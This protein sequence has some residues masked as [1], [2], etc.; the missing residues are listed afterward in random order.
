MLGGWLGMPLPGQWDLRGDAGS[1]FNAVLKCRGT[2]YPCSFTHLLLYF[3]GKGWTL[4]PLVIITSGIKVLREPVQPDTCNL[5]LSGTGVQ[6][7]CL[8][9]Q[10][11]HSSVDFLSKS[12]PCCQAALGFRTYNDRCQTSILLLSFAKLLDCPKPSVRE[13][14]LF[15]VC[16]FFFNSVIN[17]LCLA[18]EQAPGCAAGHSCDEKLFCCQ[19]FHV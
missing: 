16:F 3:W 2:N 5:Q 15:F 8:G 10:S 14:W 17:T 6:L 7:F 12:Q 1:V 18:P 19:D 11:S 9:R 4:V 13:G